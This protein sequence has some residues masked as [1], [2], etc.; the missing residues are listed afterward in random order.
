MIVLLA[1]GFNKPMA[2]VAFSRDELHARRTADTVR[3]SFALA[4][5]GA[6]ADTAAVAIGEG[7]VSG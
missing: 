6:F 4:R 1:Q 7:V 5:S 2:R 3:G